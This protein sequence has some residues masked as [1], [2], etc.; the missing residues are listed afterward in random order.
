MD[1]SNYQL[2]SWGPLAI[3]RPAV[4]VC[5]TILVVMT[6]I[7]VSIVSESIGLGQIYR[8]QNDII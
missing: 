5:P 1:E 6:M 2:T 7:L 3:D 4:G 8:G